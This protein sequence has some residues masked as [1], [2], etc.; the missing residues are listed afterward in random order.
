MEGNLKGNNEEIIENNDET[1][2]RNTVDNADSSTD[3]MICRS[4]SRKIVRAIKKK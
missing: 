2:E 3:E 4:F 1:L